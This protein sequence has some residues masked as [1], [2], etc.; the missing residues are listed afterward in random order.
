MDLKEAAEA[1][2]AAVRE[3]AEAHAEAMKSK[4]SEVSAR[5][6]MASQ[7]VELAHS[8]WREAFRTPPSPS[9]TQK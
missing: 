5:Y 4:A 7:K 9:R 2:I 8:R 3:H 1:L 6:Q